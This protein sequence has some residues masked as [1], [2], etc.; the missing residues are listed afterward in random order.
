MNNSINTGQSDA[1]MNRK[2]A[3]EWL[4][5]SEKGLRNFVA[6]GLLPEV[7]LGHRRLYQKVA[8]QRALAK[9][10]VSEVA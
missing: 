3:A 4:G 1:L 7:R 5:L 8:L 9:L 10:E 6:R 2:T